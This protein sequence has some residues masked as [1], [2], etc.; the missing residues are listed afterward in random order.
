[1]VCG[2]RARPERKII[3]NKWPC[4]DTAAPGARYPAPEI[5][6]VVEWAGIPW[7]VDPISWREIQ[8]REERPW[9]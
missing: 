8:L 1:V 3:G 9:S 2:D 7:N 5:G 4:G 6:E